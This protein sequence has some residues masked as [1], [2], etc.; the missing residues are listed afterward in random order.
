MRSWRRF[1]TFWVG[2][3][4]SFSLTGLLVHPS[5]QLG[6]A[7]PAIAQNRV[8]LDQAW[9]SVYQQ[10]PDIPK[11]NQYISAETNQVDENDT[12]VGRLIRYH[13]YEKQRPPFFRLDWK[14]TLADYLG[15]NEL[16]EPTT[17]PSAKQLKINP[18]EGDIAAIKRLNRAQRNALVQALTDAFSSVRPAQF[19]D[20]SPTAK[21]TATPKAPSVKGPGGADLLRP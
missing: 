14:L 8:Q 19:Q 21:P 20:N 11:E 2:L 16:M 10:L 9:R 6:G 17:Y 1:T 12:L 18:M 3:L 5:L 7:T 13:L 15:V 4:F